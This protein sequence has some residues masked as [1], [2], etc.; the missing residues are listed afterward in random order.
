ME[1][2]PDASKITGLKLNSKNL[3]MKKKSGKKLTGL[4]HSKS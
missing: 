4:D 1:F 2:A 3:K